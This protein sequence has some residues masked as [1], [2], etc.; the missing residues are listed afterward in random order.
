MLLAVMFSSDLL[1]V[2]TRKKKS[3]LSIIQ[4]HKKRENKSWPFKPHQQGSMG[5]C[6]HHN[7]LNQY[8]K[9]IVCLFISPKTTIFVIFAWKTPKIC[10]KCSKYTLYSRYVKIQLPWKNMQEHTHSHTHTGVSP[11][12]C[13]TPLEKQP[14]NILSSAAGKN[15]LHS[16]LHLFSLWTFP[17][18]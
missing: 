5:M 11:L 18:Y 15:L 2:R 10:S 6:V 17:Y 4:F 9:V 3:F 16:S 7:I 14:A 1:T 12:S 8:Q 13:Q